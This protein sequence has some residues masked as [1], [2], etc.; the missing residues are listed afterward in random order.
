M[1]LVSVM[2]VRVRMIMFAFFSFF[3]L[4]IRR[5]PR[6]TLFPYTTLF[7]SRV[8]LD[9]EAEI[10]AERFNPLEDSLP[11][12]QGFGAMEDHLGQAPFGHCSRKIILQSRQRIDHL[13]GRHMRTG[14]AHILR[15]V[16]V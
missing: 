16:A 14:S 5:P 8:G 10:V 7:R 9:A 2:Q 12:Q 3:F 1:W 13:A 4:M 11:V 15:D 6:S